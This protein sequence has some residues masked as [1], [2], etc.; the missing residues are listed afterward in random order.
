MKK[1]TISI[2]PFLKS[3]FIINLEQKDLAFSGGMSPTHEAESLTG[4][5]I[6]CN[7]V[8]RT[9]AYKDFHCYRG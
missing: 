6:R 9:P 5:A 1:I 8:S 4:E 2:R 7:L 3:S